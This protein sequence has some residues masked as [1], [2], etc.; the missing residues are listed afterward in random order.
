[1]DNVFYIGDIVEVLD[2]IDCETKTIATIKL[3]E[4]DEDFNNIFYL[5]LIAN[6]E[7]LNV[8]IDQ[9]IGN[10]WK[11]ISSTSEYIT[12]LSHAVE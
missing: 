3:I 7:A 2:E 12:L 6:E 1:M 5:Y 4:Q 8:N 11:I 9:R 10:Y